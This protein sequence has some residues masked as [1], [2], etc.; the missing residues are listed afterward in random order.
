MEENQQQLAEDVLQILSPLRGER[1]E[2]EWMIDAIQRG[3]FTGDDLI[4]L[5]NLLVRA[6]QSVELDERIVVLSQASELVRINREKELQERLEEQ[7]QSQ[8]LISFL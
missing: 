1:E 3:L 4:E 5:A 8:Y 2:A 6:T 7:K